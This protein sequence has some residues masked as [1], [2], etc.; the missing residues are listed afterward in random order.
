ML[1]CSMLACFLVPNSSEDLLKCTLYFITPNTLGTIVDIKDLLSP[2]AQL[3]VKSLVDVF[4]NKTYTLLVKHE[5]SGIPRL[6]QK[7]P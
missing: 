7:F 5:L 4:L 3:T 1:A 6:E 2:P